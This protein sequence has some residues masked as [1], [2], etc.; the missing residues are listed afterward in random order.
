MPTPALFTRISGSIFLFWSAPAR[1]RPVGRG[2]VDRDDLDPNAMG[3]RELRG[4]RGELALAARR[5]NQRIAA[6]GQLPRDLQPDAAGCA[7][8][9]REPFLAAVRHRTSPA[10]CP[11][12][13]LPAGRQERK[14][15]RS[16]ENL[17]AGLRRNI[18]LCEALA[19]AQRI[20]AEC[21]NRSFQISG[22]VTP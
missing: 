11:H 8:H 9:E 3:A 5:E 19:E 2:E 14:A 6:R 16:I 21:A 4:G 20:A 13:F 1:R 12:R 10:G 22:M 17:E 7:R 18:Q 15:L